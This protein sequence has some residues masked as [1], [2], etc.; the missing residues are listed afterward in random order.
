MMKL[1][2]R[3]A[4]GLLG[5][6]NWHSSGRA[7]AKNEKTLRVVDTSRRIQNRNLQK[8]GL[9]EYC[10]ESVLNGWSWSPEN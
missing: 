5:V 7:Q 1:F 9:R 3:K 6:I 2:G 10:C 4:R 8:T